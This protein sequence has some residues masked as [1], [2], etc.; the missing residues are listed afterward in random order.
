MPQVGSLLLVLALAAGCGQE[1]SDDAVSEA[2]EVETTGADEPEA[3]DPSDGPPDDEASE[4]TSGDGLDAMVARA[5]AASPC[6]SAM[7]RV[8]LFRDASGEV[9]I[10]RHEGDPMTCSHPP[11]TYV[12]PAGEIRLQQGNRPVTGPDDAAQLEAARQAVIGDL[13]ADEQTHRCPGA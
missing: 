5:C 3:G 12:S 8:T 13:T 2:D 1:P 7:S 4:P 10:L 9:A 11:W 6:A